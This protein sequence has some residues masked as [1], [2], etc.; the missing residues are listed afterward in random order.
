KPHFGHCPRGSESEVRRVPHWAQ[1]ETSC[2]PVMWTGRGPNVSL[3]TGF[4]GEDFWRS[5]PLS[6][7]PCWRYLRS[8][9]RSPG[10]QFRDGTF[11]RRK[12]KST[13]AALIVIR[14]S[15]CYHPCVAVIAVGGRLCRSGMVAAAYFGF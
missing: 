11:S 2:V 4:C 6:W 7:Y 12:G 1:R 8:D 9:T 15:G 3:R 5:S 13:S 10:T 14:Q